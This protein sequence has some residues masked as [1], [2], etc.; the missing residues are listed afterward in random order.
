MITDH[1]NNY[2]YLALKSIPTGNGYMKPTKSISK[3]FRD[4]SS[5]RNSDV[6]CLNCFHS[7]RTNKKLKNHQRLCNDHD[8][9]N[10]VMPEEGKNIF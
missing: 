8:Y 4:I 2:H 9:C 5:K 1:K 3:L 6:Y 7:F 10:V